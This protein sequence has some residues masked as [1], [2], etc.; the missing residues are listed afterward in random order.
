DA[1]EGGIA[2]VNVTLTG[3]GADGVIG[4]ADDTSVTTTT[5]AAGQYSFS[6]LTPGNYQVTFNQPSGYNF[7]TQNAGG[8]D[9]VDSDADATTGKSQTFTL[10]SG[11]TNTTIDA[12][13]FRPASIG[14]FV[15]EDKN[16]NGVQDAG[17]GGIAG[18]NVTLTGAGADGV[19]GT[20]D[21]TSVTTTTDAAG[22]YSFSGLT[23]GNYQVTFNQ[24]S[25]YNFTKQ[26]AGS[27][28]AVDSDANATTGKS[29]VVT[30][31]SGEN[32][33][34]IDAGLF[35][36]ASIGD[37]VWEDKNGNG[38]Q[39][40]GENGLAC[41]DVTLKG[42]GKDGI[43]GTADDTSITTTTDHNGKYSFTNLTPGVPYQVIFEKPT[44]YNFTTQNAGSNDAVDSD[45]NTSTGKS[46]TF[47]LVSGENNTTIDAGLFKPASIGNF[48]WEDKN[49]NGIQDTGEN[50]L[51]CVDVT[52]K[53][54]GG[55]GI[56]GTADDTSVTTT[57]DHYGKYSF[58]GLTPGVPYQVIFEKPTGYNFTTQNAGSNDAVDSDADPTTGKSQ[59]VTL[60][61]GEYNKTIDAGLV[62]IR[63]GDLS[64]TKTDC[65]D[66]VAPGQKVTYK[67]VVSNNGPSTATNALVSD[68]FPSILTNVRWT[69]EATCGASGNQASGTTSIND[70]VTLE[71]GSSIIYTVTGT[72]AANAAIDK[73]SNFA[74]GPNNTNLGQSITTAN[75]VKAEAFYINNGYQSTNTFL[76]QRNQADDQGLGVWSNGEPNPITSG[77]DV[78][79]L[80]NQL[81]QEVIRLTKAD[82]EKW[83]SLWVSSLDGGGSGNAEKGTLYWSNSATPD[84]NTLTTKFTF[85][86]GDFGSDVEGDLLKLSK[87]SSFDANA[88]YLFFIAGPNA[89]GTNN[90]YL[91]WK[92]TTAT[93]TLNNTA[94]VT[95]PNG[96]VDTNP[97]N[98]SDTDSDFLFTNPGVRTPGFWS[99]T[100]WQKFWDGVAGNEPAQVGTKNFPK[101]DLLSSLYVNSDQPGK[102]LDPVTGKYDIGLLIGDFNRNGKTDAGENTLFYTRAQALQIVD[103]SK[104][105]DSKDVRYTLGRDL[106]ASWL[107]YLAG[108]PIDTADPCDK[109]TK[110]YISEGINWLQALTPDEPQNSVNQGSGACDNK[111]DGA[112]NLLTGSTVSSPAV[113]AS[114][115]Y[116]TLGVSSLS[117]LLNPYYSGNT[118]VSYSIEAGKTIHN[119]LDCY[120]NTGFGADGA[121]YGG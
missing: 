83:T 120:N 111:G 44:G 112:L 76:W 84:L 33:T 30:L 53:G 18:V 116:W 69:S 98:N 73:L 4:T 17:E 16:V 47:T 88:K 75:G 22:Q 108:N 62:K 26:D 113:T 90:D 100:N 99:N 107:N 64:I 121:F 2:G 52:L 104:Q 1:G 67:I 109:D 5:D 11:E 55:D 32:N 37:F 101:G 92:V 45:A 21:D 105:P 95:A 96:F 3:A 36:P 9:T 38:I 14:D 87:S 19:I 118:N 93:A 23:P 43:F 12:G 51:A 97:N 27:N 7:T 80:S 8:D 49:G 74:S 103:S 85:Q 54:A 71:S 61:S 72:V 119:A 42:A 25:G 102:V 89:A 46:Q 65:E 82:G 20:A 68:I 34:T 10:I 39:D 114:S 78:N 91:V 40:A 59:I 41:V 77:G 106:V 29:Q 35:R 70:Y 15:W 110:Y 57:T 115:I 6:G 94:T 28:D 31:A 117:I 24:P 13:L 58:S 81:N 60:T 63:Y 79:E 66:T 48:V 50:G 56:F 86:Y